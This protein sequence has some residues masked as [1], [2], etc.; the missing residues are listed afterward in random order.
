MLIIQTCKNKHRILESDIPDQP[1]P[2]WPWNKYLNAFQDNGY[3]DANLQALNKYI[4]SEG[5]KRNHQ[6]NWR[7]FTPTAKPVVHETPR[8]FKTPF[9]TG[10]KSNISNRRL[11]F[12]AGS[13]LDSHYITTP[14]SMKTCQE[15]EN[16]AA[17]PQ[18]LEPKTALKQEDGKL[19]LSSFI[20][21]KSV[22]PLDHLQDL[23]H[24]ITI[25]EDLYPRLTNT[26][27]KFIK[28]KTVEFERKYP[29]SKEIFRL[30]SQIYGTL[31]R[32]IFQKFHSCVN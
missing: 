32:K 26:Q 17:N 23:S 10:L 15:I 22:N 28:L 1:P 31:L 27:C 19:Q 13:G 14:W 7:Q 20:E 6:L 8:K 21:I 9:R 3:I 5:D 29:S 24:N 2:R 18:P 4:S 30:G 16:L 25:P 12:A 11:V